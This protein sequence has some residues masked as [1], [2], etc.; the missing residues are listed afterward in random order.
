MMR[1]RLPWLTVTILIALLIFFLSSRPAPSTGASTLDAPA[2]YAAHFLLYAVLAFSLL[3]TLTPATGRGASL[4]VLAVLLYGISDELHQATVA[5]R[6]ASVA[7]A[8]VDFVGAVAGVL[9]P[10]A[11]QHEP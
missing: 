6:D 5:T 8:A 10:R 9:L 1:P 2:S 3:K 11:F 7:D 4:V